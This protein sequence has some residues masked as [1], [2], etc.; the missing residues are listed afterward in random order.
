M[1]I[2]KQLAIARCD[3]SQSLIVIFSIVTQIWVVYMYFCLSRD[4]VT[5]ELKVQTQS[6]Q[7]ARRKHAQT[8]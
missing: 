2:Q 8:V 3:V 1:D 5:R 6:I 7:G 4:T